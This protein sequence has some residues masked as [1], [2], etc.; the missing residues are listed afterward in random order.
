MI[1]LKRLCVFCGSS[2][3]FDLV[4]RQ[5]SAAFGSLLATQGIELVFGGGSVGLMGAVADAVLHAGGRVIGVIPHFLATRELLHEGVTEIRRTS[6][7]HERKAAMSDLAD[8]FVALPG[9]LGTFEELFEVLT[10]AQLGLHQKPI[11][12]LNI[13]GYF[14]PLVAMV[15]R[16]ICDG[17]CKEV[18]RRLFVVNE[19]PA[20]LL[21]L[22]RKHQPPQVKKWIQSS[23]ET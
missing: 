12:L 8:A 2:S 19:D 14:D 13:D 22:L 18:H 10:W 16:A 15:D 1:E 17:F 11:G 9:G 5:V 23:E 3:G 7:M 6:D 4:H 20:R 21:E